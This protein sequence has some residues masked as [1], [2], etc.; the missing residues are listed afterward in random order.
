MKTGISTKSGTF[1]GKVRLSKKNSRH[2]TLR[3]GILTTTTSKWDK[4][5]PSCGNGYVPFSAQQAEREPKGSLLQT[6]WAFGK[7]GDAKKG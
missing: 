2:K 6:T 7:G 1:G 5:Q 4:N 3:E